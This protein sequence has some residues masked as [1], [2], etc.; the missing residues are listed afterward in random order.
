MGVVGLRRT[1]FENLV[2]GWVSRFGGTQNAT[3]GSKVSQ[4]LKACNME[5]GLTFVAIRNLASSSANTSSLE[6]LLPIFIGH[7]LGTIGQS[8]TIFLV[9]HTM[10][11]V[12][13]AKP[14][15]VLHIACGMKLFLQ[16]FV[17]WNK[18]AMFFN[19]EFCIL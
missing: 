16:S 10:F 15:L 19:V 9:T 3:E 11:D 13:G 14:K 4:L 5:K 8:K 1:L 7:V 18:S 6:R 12:I 2:V 17:N